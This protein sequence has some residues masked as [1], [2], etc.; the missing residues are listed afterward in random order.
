MTNRTH[1]GI[2]LLCLLAGAACASSDTAKPA[3]ANGAGC[4]PTGDGYFRAH[5]R[6]A[7]DL[8]LD[9]RDA[10]MKCEGGPRPD[11]RGMRVSFAGPLQSDGRRV[12]FVFGLADLGEGVAGRNVPTNLTL[13]FEGESRLFATRG[14]DK[15]TTDTLEQ[16]RVGA[17]GGEVRTWR[18][19]AR[20]F[21]TE[22]ATTLAQDARIVVTTFDFSGLVRIGEATPTPAPR[23]ALPKSNAAP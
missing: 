22:P 8:D 9:W 15:C 17:L 20:G 10:E 12:R 4:L 6:G 18:V 14:D 5:V 16:Q 21:C 13:I 11:D 19:T 1:T 3:H 2:A 23:D 7:L